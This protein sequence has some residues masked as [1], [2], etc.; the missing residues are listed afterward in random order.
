M[1]EIVQGGACG[2]LLRLGEAKSPH[3]DGALSTGAG[4]SG[5]GH[6]RLKNRPRFSMGPD[7]GRAG[8]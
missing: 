6:W 8:Q 5:P 7:E 2:R 1:A 3:A 4:I